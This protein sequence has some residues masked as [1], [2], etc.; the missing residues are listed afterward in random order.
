MSAKKRLPGAPGTSGC[1]ANRGE[2]TMNMHEWMTSSLPGVVKRLEQSIMS[3]F[4]NHTA[5]GLDLA[6]RNAIYDVLDDI[7]AVLFPDAYSRTKVDK[8]DIVFFLDDLARHICLDLGSHMRDVFKFRC[9]QRDKCEN[10]TCEQRAEDAL[11]HLIVSLPDIRAVLLQDITAAFEGDPAAQSMDEIVLSYPCIE[12]IATHRVAHLLYD[13]DVPIIPRIMS[14]RA[15]SRTGIDIHPGAKIG[16]RF[17]IDHGTGVVIG[18]TATIGRN[19][20]LYQGVTLGALSF[21]LDEKGN[22][23]KGI[24]R[25]PD[26]E[27]DVIIYA[28]ATILGGDTVIGKGAVIGGNTWITKSVPPGGRAYSERK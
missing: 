15:H 8:A 2:G 7:L 27:D 22:P 17:F 13:L 12:A 3:G 5:E 14:E 1:P 16:P 24:K 18:E 25:H 11:K 10:C 23:V 4:H 26:I 20:K 28:N 21:P 19:V 6:G 9:R